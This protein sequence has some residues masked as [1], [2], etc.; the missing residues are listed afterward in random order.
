MLSAWQTAVFQGYGVLKVPFN[1]AGIDGAV[2]MTGQDLLYLTRQPRQLLL[3]FYVEIQVP[4]RTEQK[5]RTVLLDRIAGKQQLLAPVNKR[6]AAPGVA[7]D[8]DCFQTESAAFKNIA[9]FQRGETGGAADQIPVCGMEEA[10]A[11]IL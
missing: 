7:G 4:V 1:I 10:F 2:V 3:A 9:F 11:K 8:F 6:S 5:D